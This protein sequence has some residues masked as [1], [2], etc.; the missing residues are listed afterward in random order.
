MKKIKQLSKILFLGLAFTVAS[1]SS[2]SEGGSVSAGE[3]T[4]SAKVDGTTITSIPQ[5]TFAYSTS[6]G[7]Q[8]TGTNNSAK[9]LAIQILTFDGVGKYNM[10]GNNSLAIGTYT[11][12]DL[13]DPQNVNNVW[14]APYNE[15]MVDGFVDVTE[16]TATHVK[17][18]FSFK[19]QNQ[20]GTVKDIT[21]GSFNIKITA[22]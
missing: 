17:G 16:V 2:D 14:M 18:T 8:I 4:I 21:N 9:N 20:T 12:V 10:G 5:A 1:C 13:N 6:V 7:L 19:A 11:E 3:G 22:M 15:N